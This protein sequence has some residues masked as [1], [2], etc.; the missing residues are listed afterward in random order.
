MASTTDY[1][2]SY[3]KCLFVLTLLAATTVL[4]GDAG[5]HPALVTGI[6]LLQNPGAEAGLLS[7]PGT[8][9]LPGWQTQSG[10]FT[11]VV[12][13]GVGCYLCPS[14]SEATRIGG[15]VNFFYAGLTLQFATLVQTVSVAS[16]SQAIDAG[17]R[18]ARFQVQMGT[19]TGTAQPTV[20]FLSATGTVLGSLALPLVL[21]SNQAVYTLN[22]G[23]GP[24]PVGTRSVRVTL[25]SVGGNGSANAFF[26]NVYLGL[27]AVDPT[28][29]FVSDQPGDNR[30]KINVS[31]NT[32]Q[33]GGQSGNGTAIPLASMGIQR[34]GVFWFFGADNPEAMVKVLNGCSSN[35]AYWVFYSAGTNVG[36]TTTVTDTK[37]G[38]VKSYQNPDLTPAAPV[39]D[40]NAFPCP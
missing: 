18:I 36:M 27:E 16:D 31:W 38:R 14:P 33:G 28:T 29:L 32:V 2:L 4:A 7:G 11:G 10:G 24:V 8:V 34:G 39:Q 20:D 1:R 17:Q 13:G 21:G 37:T 12:Y 40:V 26:D 19:Y 5:G 9:S 35:G 22:S 3:L 6:N 25:T 23:S 15:G 30:F